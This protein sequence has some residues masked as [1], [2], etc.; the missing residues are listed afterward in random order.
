MMSGNKLD[1]KNEVFGPV[2]LK[3]KR[4]HYH[5]SKQ[6]EVLVEAMAY[7]EGQGVHLTRFDADGDERID[8]INIMYAGETQYVDDSWLWP[9]NAQYRIQVG[10]LSTE[11]YQI[12]SLES[13]SIGTFCHENGHM[14][15]RFPDLYDYGFRDEDN[16]KS[17]GLGKYCLMSA[18][19]HLNNGRTPAPICGYFRYLAGWHDREV[20]INTV[21]SLEIRGADFNTIVRFDTGR[22]NEYFII[23]NRWQKG[24]DSYCPAGGLAVYHCDT[25]GSNEYQDG[26]PSKHYQ[27]ALIQA[28]GNNDLEKG[29]NMG[30]AG[31][32]YRNIGGIAVAPKLWNEADSGLIIREIGP[33]GEIMRFRVGPS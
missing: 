5:Y 17:G 20:L 29:R 16:V 19:N 32:F 4:G 3:H 33:A 6:N 9:H 10:D 26:S 27:C 7:I 1:Y 30:D 23:E 8:A 2:K 18:G 13:A 31:D 12:C 24:I 28:D 14:L 25:Q 11:Y 22:E 21:D 15:C